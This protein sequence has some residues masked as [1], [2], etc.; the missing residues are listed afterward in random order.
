MES[1]VEG[2]TEIENG[3]QYTEVT[4]HK[5][6]V[7]SERANTHTHISRTDP[8]AMSQV[9]SLGSGEMLKL[10]QIIWRN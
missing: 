8:E 9:F 7:N 10:S 1:S 2:K 6:E 5:A 3:A 4:P